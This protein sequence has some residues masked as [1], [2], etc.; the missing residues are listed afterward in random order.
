MQAKTNGEKRLLLAGVREDIANAINLQLAGFCQVSKVDE[1][2]TLG[3]EILA[4]ATLAIL[5]FSNGDYLPRRISH[6]ISQS[7]D[8]VSCQFYH[9]GDHPPS[10][11]LVSLLPEINP[12]P[13]PIDFGYLKGLLDSAS[14][15]H[16]RIQKL[17]SDQVRIRLVNELSS[18]LLKVNSRSQISEALS[19]T[20]PKI[21]NTPFV[22][23]VFPAHNHPVLFFDSHIA[24]TEKMTSTLFDQLANGWGILRPDAPVDW[25]WISELQSVANSPEDDDIDP[26]TLLSIPITRGNQTEGFL[27]FHK[28]NREI[29]ESL[30]QT[31]FLIGDLIGVLM[32]N[33][34]LREELER[35]ATRDGLTG[36]LNRQT[37]FD[38]L[39]KECQRANRYANHFSVV[40]FDLDHFKS[41]NDTYLHQGGDQALRDVADLVRKSV[42]EV[43]IAGRFG[44]EEFIVIL[45]YTNLDGAKC[46]AERLRRNIADLR[47]ECEEGTF[48]VT[49]SAGV[50]CTPGGEDIKADHLVALADT[51]L[52]KAKQNGRNK[53][54][55]AVG[56]DQFEEVIEAEVE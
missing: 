22:L 25:K 41:V 9:L 21:L 49:I 12:L 4:S 5:D 10:P 24:I 33:L 2:D 42:R 26:N 32:Y 31:Y 52:Y 18:N 8:S 46:W 16:Q 51:A 55:F 17:A 20:L 7:L 3:M 37:T 6:I 56:N 29:D 11:E 23:L 47:I 30:H 50:A 48:S 34:H 40:M 19:R 13:N 27:T 43:D 53:V 36:L 35:R 14:I 15:H 28:G 44:G 54:F 1:D 39:E 45:P 38:Q